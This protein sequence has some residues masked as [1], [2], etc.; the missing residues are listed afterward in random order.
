M[1]AAR[2]QLRIVP[3]K[4]PATTEFKLTVKEYLLARRQECTQST[5]EK[6]GH[7]LEQLT[8][9]L[10]ERGATRWE[11]IS[12]LLLREW[13][14]SLDPDWSPATH[15]HAITVVRGFLNWYRDEGLVDEQLA[16]A[17]RPP[18]IKVRIQRTLSEDEIWKLLDAC[19]NS[20][21]GLRDA[22]IV[23]LMI[24]TGL[25]ASELCRLQWDDLTFDFP[26]GDDRLNF[27]LVVG[28]GGNREPVFFGEETNSR[29][30][31]WFR[32]RIARPGIHTVFVSLGG[33]TPLEPLTRHGLGHL[34][35]ELGKR[36]RVPD[37]SP[38]S[39]RRTFATM[40]D[41]AGATTRQ[42]QALGRWS[43][44]KMVEHYTRAMKP[45]L[46]FG[47]FSPGNRFKK[48]PR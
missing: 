31:A 29:L 36:A 47:K 38:H 37:V 16:T 17:L 8:T 33:N 35:R 26:F 19:D 15:R 42:I 30:R 10:A 24:D 14:A 32:V 5:I 3:A 43:D 34:L 39:L 2:P 46:H 25:R 40:L 4:R 23:L 13:A 11:D 28:K 45:G 12:R 22:A 21:F 1:P 9:W 20:A 27:A 6:Y 7:R 18:K 41:E 48:R 44:I